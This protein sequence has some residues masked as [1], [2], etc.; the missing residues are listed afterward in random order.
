M[1]SQTSIY[2][3]DITN[4]IY[5][6]DIINIYILYGGKLWQQENLANSLHEHIG[7]RKFGEL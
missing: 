5:T 7:R 1:T 3:D 6:D 4:T 2:T